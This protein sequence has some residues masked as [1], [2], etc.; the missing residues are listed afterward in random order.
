MTTPGTVTE[1][2]AFLSAAG[3]VDDYR[4]CAD[5]IVGDRADAPHPV[6][7]ASVDYTFRFEGNSDPGDSSIVLGV[8]CAE[9]GRKGVI[10]SA[11]GADADPESAAMLIALT[12]TAEH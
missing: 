6:A 11:Y 3:Y 12:A 4:L 2:L 8:R 7:T 10:V 5:G 9:W 1:A